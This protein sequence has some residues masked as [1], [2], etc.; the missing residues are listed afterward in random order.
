MSLWKQFVVACALAATAGAADT[1]QMKD[2]TVHTGQIVKVE[3]GAVVLKLPVG[4]V[5]LPLDAIK[6]VQVDK[7]TT[8]DAAVAAL[9]ERKFADAVAGL[10]PIADRYAGIPGI[11]WAQE[12]IAL[13]AE[14]YFGVNDLANAKKTF[15]IMKKLY[16]GMIGVEVKSARLL[17]EEKQYAPAIELLGKF[18]D[19][20]L[21]HDSLTDEQEMAIAEALVLRGDCQRATKELDNAIDSY[22][23]VV[24]LFDLNADR[25][26]EAKYKAAVAFEEKGNLKRA[27]E[28]YEEVLREFGKSSY[29]GEAQK[30][31]AAVKAKSG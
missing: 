25:A 15:E 13:L 18:L 12:A 14:A 11:P 5:P 16:P 10:K 27:Q 21:K 31:L 24:T 8:Y 1:V 19:P 28:S 7:P 22:L 9:R 6:A 30:R 4:D 26:A 3:G 29:A 17:Y 2:G 20:I 23:L